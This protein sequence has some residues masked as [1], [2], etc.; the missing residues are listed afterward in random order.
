MTV[1]P[2][3]HAHQPGLHAVGGQ[4]VLEGVAEALH[5]PAVDLG[6]L[7]AFEQGER[8]QPPGAR[9]GGRAQGDGELLGVGRR[10]RRGTGMG[11]AR[12]RGAAWAAP[13]SRAGRAVVGARPRRRT[14]LA[15]PARLRRASLV[16]EI[17]PAYAPDGRGR[18]AGR[19]RSALGPD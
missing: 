14:R 17:G 6:G 4:G 12:A 3:G 19:C 13:V 16:V 10:L 18:M 7:G 1:G 11:T 5:V 9:L 8:R 2:N 15:G